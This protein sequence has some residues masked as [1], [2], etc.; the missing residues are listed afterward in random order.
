MDTDPLAPVAGAVVSAPVMVWRALARLPHASTAVQVRA[1]RRAL[2][3]KLVTTSLYDMDTGPL[4]SVAVATPVALV[5]VFAGYSSVTLAGTC[6]TGLVVSTTVMGWRALALLPHA[7]TAVQ[8]RAMRRALPHKLVTTSLYVM[9]D[10]PLASVAV[11]TPV[12]LVAVFAGYSSVT[13][14][15]TCNTGA[16]VSRTVMVWRALPRLPHASTAVQVRAMRRALPHKLV[17]TSLYVMDTGP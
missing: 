8:V 12:A 16:V 7:S 5:A 6:N 14:A 10:G 11:A 1:M 15:G 13:L 3:H 17:T 2:P 9:V 4:A